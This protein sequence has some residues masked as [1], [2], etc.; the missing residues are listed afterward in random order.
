M[1]GGP[2]LLI[3]R[4]SL[5]EESEKSAGAGKRTPFR[6][7]FRTGFCFEMVLRI[8]Q[9]SGIRSE[10]YGPRQIWSHIIERIQFCMTSVGH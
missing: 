2:N 5:G 4:T 7:E 10:L 3:S 6:H 9:L 1:L 8:D